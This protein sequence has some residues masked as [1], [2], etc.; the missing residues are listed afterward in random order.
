MNSKR[1]KTSRHGMAHRKMTCRLCVRVLIISLFTLFPTGATA[2]AQSADNAQEAKQ[3]FEK[4]YGMVFGNEGS[5][6]SYA[7]NII[8]IY[9]TQGSI[10]YKGKKLR[11]AESRYASWNDGKTAYM[12]DKKKKTVGIYRADDD[13]KD[14]YLSKFKFNIN[15][16]TYSWKRINNMIEITVKAKH[17]IFFG[18]REAKG[19]IYE[20]NYYPVSLRIKVAF[21]WTTVKISNFRAGG[22][23]D[24]MFVFPK[25]EF[26]GYSFDNHLKD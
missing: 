20:S 16:Y 3:I 26:A 11:Y 12:V 10:I 1:I 21:F 23:S 2:A 18:V 15:D 25:S 14:N 5:A 6:L 7:V 19:L 8:G 13:N 22:I 17:S 4:V 9:K 24:Q